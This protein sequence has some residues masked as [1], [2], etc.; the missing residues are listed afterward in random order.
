MSRF[1]HAKKI[2]AKCQR[3][4]A[5]KGFGRVLAMQSDDP[6]IVPSQKLLG[7]RDELSAVKKQR[8]PP[9]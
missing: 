2:C 6:R 5:R 7:A 4:Y 1:K 9:T 3:R 8:G